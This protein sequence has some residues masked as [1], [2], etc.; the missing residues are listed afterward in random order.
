MSEDGEGPRDALHAC[1]RSEQDI[2]PCVAADVDR[3]VYVM[4]GLENVSGSQ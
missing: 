4:N 2:L 3:D 1:I